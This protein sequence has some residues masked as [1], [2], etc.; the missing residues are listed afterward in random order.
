MTPTINTIATI[1]NPDGTTAYQIQS[2]QYPVKEAA[3]TGLAMLNAS[4]MELGQI[5]N[6]AIEYG[7]N[8]VVT[9]QR[10][11]VFIA[12]AL[13]RLK[14]LT[15]AVCGFY[16][17]LGTILAAAETTLEEVDRERLRTLQASIRPFATLREEKGSNHA[18]HEQMV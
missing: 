2:Q 1:L 14:S 9:N 11:S 10:L 17:E 18:D 7:W 5:V 16:Q 4:L 6:L 8:G 15:D 3:E 12:E 13:A